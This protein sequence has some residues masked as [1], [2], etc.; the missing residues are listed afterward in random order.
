MKR[1]ILFCLTVACY[2]WNILTAQ[3]LVPIRD[4]RTGLYGYKYENSDKWVVKPKYTQ[5]GYF[6]EGLAFVIKEKG[7]HKKKGGGI[8]CTKHLAG[9]IDE[10]G[11]IAIPLKFEWANDFS[12]GLAVVKIWDETSVFY[13]RFG[14]ID[15]SGHIVIPPIYDYAEEFRNGRAKVKWYDEYGICWAT[16]IDIYGNEGKKWQDG[17]SKIPG[18]QTRPRWRY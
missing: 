4:S 2:I 18:G 7:V 17:N 13:W 3:N 9:Y 12:E 6:S 14:Y 10:K 11:K 1:K 15:K 5:V 8:L 16:Y